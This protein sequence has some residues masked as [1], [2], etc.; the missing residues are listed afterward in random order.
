MTISLISETLEDY[1]LRLEAPFD[2]SD[3]GA[4]G[5]FNAAPGLPDGADNSQD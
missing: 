3:L 2:A 5:V 1:V 4:N